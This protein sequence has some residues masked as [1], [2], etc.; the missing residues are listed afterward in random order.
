MLKRLQK[1]LGGHFHLPDRWTLNTDFCML[2]AEHKF[3]KIETSI[4]SG[5]KCWIYRYSI[6]Q[7]FLIMT[8]IISYEWKEKKFIKVKLYIKHLRGKKTKCWVDFPSALRGKN[9]DHFSVSL[10]RYIY[11]LREQIEGRVWIVVIRVT[12]NFLSIN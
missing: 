12:W 2:N 3:L 7:I 8:L 11:L 10:A 6:L 5:S 1:S 9:K 4:L